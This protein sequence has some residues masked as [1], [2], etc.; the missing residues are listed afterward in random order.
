LKC[1]QFGLKKKV[2]PSF[3][4]ESGDTV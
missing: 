2:K 4:S 1:R 3:G